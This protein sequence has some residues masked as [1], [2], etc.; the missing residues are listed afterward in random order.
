MLR[1]A[2][3]LP[4]PGLRPG[5]ALPALARPPP[6][7]APPSAPARP[8]APPA[9]RPAPTVPPLPDL[10][11]HGFHSPAGLLPPK[12]PALLLLPPSLLGATPSPRDSALLD[13]LLPA[14][15]CPSR[16]SAPPL[17]CP[18]A[19]ASPSPAA[20]PT[21]PGTAARVVSL[22]A[23][24]RGGPRRSGQSAAAPPRA[25]LPAPALQRAPRIRERPHLPPA[26][27]RPAL[28]ASPALLP[29]SRLSAFACLIWAPALGPPLRAFL[30]PF[31]WPRPALSSSCAQRA[32]VARLPPRLPPSSAPFL[33]AS[34]RPA[35][36]IS[37]TAA[38]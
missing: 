6:P 30:R 12:I 24:L 26:S 38:A 20:P 17:A 5:P 16:P 21:A 23:S 22:P 9:L 4:R 35:Q 29:G 8:S 36:A 37:C 25:R 19:R 13:R 27:A 11:L 34:P 2:P 28:S 10:P 32:Q 3:G 33:R 14:R 15:L 7:L 18:S 1:V 31:H